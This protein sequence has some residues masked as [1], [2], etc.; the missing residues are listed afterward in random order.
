MFN[1]CYLVCARVFVSFFSFRGGKN[2]FFARAL[3]ICCVFFCF[4]FL[5]VFWL[6]IDFLVIIL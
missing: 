4:Y 6:I 1:L 5:C 3:L 2:F